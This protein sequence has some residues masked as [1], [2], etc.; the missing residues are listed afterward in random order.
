MFAIGDKILYPMHGAG[1]IREI[2][3]RDILG[4]N[5]RYYVL[6][7]PFGD[8]RVMI[9]VDNSEGIGVRPIISEEDIEE[10]FFVL[11]AETSKMSGSWNRRQRENMEKLRT[12]DVLQVAEVV[13]NLL[14]TE[15]SKSLSAGEK[16][17]LHNARQILESEL[18]LASGMD[19]QKID[20]LVEEA[21]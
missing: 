18:T 16:K 15:R 2:E 20:H 6:H 8:M 5:R 12:G 13:R 4:E 21:V 11:R 1:V 14:R 9:P 10:V 19:P 17:L 3:E 7:M